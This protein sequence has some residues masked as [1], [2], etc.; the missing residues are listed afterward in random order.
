MVP[1]LYPLKGLQGR[2]DTDISAKPLTQFSI[3]PMIIRQNLVGDEYSFYFN[4]MVYNGQP[5]RGDT[6]VDQSVLKAK[7]NTWLKPTDRKYIKLVDYDNQKSKF[8]F[9]IDSWLEDGLKDCKPY[10]NYMNFSRSYRLSKPLPYM[11]TVYGM[12]M[13][14]GKYISERFKR[15]LS[16]KVELRKDMFS[17]VEKATNKTL[18]LNSLSMF[19]FRYDRTTNSIICSVKPTY[20]G[21]IFAAATALSKDDSWKK[22]VNF[23]KTVGMFLKLS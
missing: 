9:D 22:K 1:N 18:G 23:D 15:N 17:M 11:V 2:V 19:E 8:V 7:L 5:M 12:E 6:K 21:M 10:D 14:F 20:M 4:N 13:I 16:K 3:N